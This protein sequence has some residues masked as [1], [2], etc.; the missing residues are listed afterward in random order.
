MKRLHIIQNRSVNGRILSK[1]AYGTFPAVSTASMYIFRLQAPDISSRKSSCSIHSPPE[2]DAAVNAFPVIR[3]ILQQLFHQLI[4]RHPAAYDAESPGI[5]APGAAAAF[6]AVLLPVKAAPLRIRNETTAR[7]GGRTT[8]AADTF[9]FIIGEAVAFF[10][11]LR[12]VAPAAPQIAALENT[13][14]LT[15]GPSKWKISVC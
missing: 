5:T 15:P 6:Y 14:V 2:G 8:A 9:L 11:G 7:T 12:I 13:A 1:S 3:R 4:R 10:I